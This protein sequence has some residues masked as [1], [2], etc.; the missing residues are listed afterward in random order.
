MC[1]R[2]FQTLNINRLLKAANAMFVTNREKYGGG[3]YNMCPTNFIPA[4]R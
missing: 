1:G 3:T 2:V 4:I